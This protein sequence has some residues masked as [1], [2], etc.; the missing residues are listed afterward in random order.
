M[1]H[2]L[3]SFAKIGWKKRGKTT[4][5]SKNKINIPVHITCTFGE[6]V[7]NN[8]LRVFFVQQKSKHP[9]K[10]A[11]P[12]FS[13]KTIK[14]HHC[15]KVL[16]LTTKVGFGRV[17]HGFCLR[18]MAFCPYVTVLQTH[19]R[20]FSTNRFPKNIMMLHQ[21]VWNLHR[22]DYQ[23]RVI[24]AFKSTSTI[25]VAVFVCEIRDKYREHLALWQH[26]ENAN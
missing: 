26:Q 12:C 11:K 25:L 3:F 21:N 23:G 2:V 20:V 6:I 5:M 7:L 13:F 24:N 1:S 19:C 16:S 9:D 15:G 14:L 8:S 10:Q 18:N 4:L 22:W 17:L